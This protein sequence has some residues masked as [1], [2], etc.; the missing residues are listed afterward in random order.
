M[1]RAMP[2]IL[3]LPLSLAIRAP[4]EAK[5]WPQTPGRTSI[6]AALRQAGLDTYWRTQVTLEHGERIDKM[7]AMEENLYLLTDRHRVIVIS[8]ASGL[9]K[10]THSFG[11]RLGKLYRPCHGAGVLLSETPPGVEKIVTPPDLRALKAYNVVFFNTPNCAIAL[12]RETGKQLRKMDFSVR[13][14][15]FTA[16]TGGACDGEYFYVGASNG[17][18]Y[19]IQVNAGIIAWILRTGDM[20]TA[21][22]HCQKAGETR[23]VFFAGEDSEL[24]VAQAGSLLSTIWPP[25]GTRTWPAMAG[26]VIA[27]FHVDDRACFIPCEERRV[28]AFS[29]AGGNPI[30][31]FSCKGPLLDPIQVSENTVFQY[32]RGDKLYA[33]NPANGKL[34]WALPEGRRV[35]ASMPL[36]DTPTA[37]LV[38]RSGNLLV[39]DEI[40]GKVSASVRLKGCQLFADN[41]SA[42]AIYVARRAGR[43]YCLR[44]LG[45]PHLSEDVLRKT[46]SGKAEPKKAEPKKPEPKMPKP[47]KA[48]PKET[49]PKEAEPKK[50]AP[51]KIP[52]KKVA[53]KK[54]KPKRVK[55]RR[56]R[57]KK[58]KPGPNPF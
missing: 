12:D 43:V 55:P 14:D 52:P 22:P 13:P 49:E 5:A 28:Y 4:V 10:W 40:L 36:N 31:R 48:E 6:P 42:P 8:A 29:L 57:P 11:R 39:V 18:C 27:E 35:L 3:A 16:T 41:T 9:R 20:M 17:R 37:Y 2:L 23:R 7:Y 24:H 58:A 33:I 54:V 30:W 50:V 26:P 38:D 46:P 21:A 25:A 44:H 19:S 32:A 34:R 53:P 15:E 51:K 45:A 56:A 47:R 1:R